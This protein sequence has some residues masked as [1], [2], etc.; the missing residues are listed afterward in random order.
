[1][2][3]VDVKNLKN[4]VV[5]KLTLDDAVFDYTASETLVWEAVRA[6]LAG[7]RKGT[8]ATK[9]RALVSGAGRKLWRQKGTGRARVGSLRSPLWR[10][11]GTVFGPQPRDYAQA[12]PKKKRRGAMKMVLSDKLRNQKITVIDEFVMDTPRTKDF[13][14]VLKTLDLDSKVL[15]VDE[16]ENRNLYLSSRNLPSVKTVTSSGLNVYDLLNHEHLLISKQAL[17]SIQEV[18]QK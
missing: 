8:H 18:L 15:V 11:G 7:Q 16:K 14:A 13:L 3:E 17:L 4:E 12:L 5:D 1:M 10:K 2:A 6:Y 9:N